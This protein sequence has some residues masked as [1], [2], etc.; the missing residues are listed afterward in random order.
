MMIMEYCPS[1]LSEIIYRENQYQ[2]PGSPVFLYQNNTQ[3]MCRATKYAMQVAGGLMD[4]HGMGYVHR[5][6]KPDN[7]LVGFAFVDN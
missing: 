3:A 5:D 6:L 1:T 7:V 4:I 2:A